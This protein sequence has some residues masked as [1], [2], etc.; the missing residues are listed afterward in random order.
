MALIFMPLLS[1]GTDAWRP[2]AAQHISGDTYQVDGPMPRDEEWAFPPFTIVHCEQKAFGDGREGL[3]AVR[4]A[5]DDE[6]L[7]D[8]VAYARGLND[9]ELQGYGDEF[10]E[11]SREWI[12][13]QRELARRRALPTWAKVVWGIIAVAAAYYAMSAA[14]A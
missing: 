14:L 5:S 12:I 11:G 8:P 2:V 10:G 13:A 9:A 1:E 3:V 6:P 4:E 7:P